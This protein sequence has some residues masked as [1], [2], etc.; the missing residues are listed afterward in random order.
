MG[1]RAWRGGRDWAKERWKRR[2][3]IAKIRIN[4]R[5]KVPFWRKGAVSPRF[6]IDW[7]TGVLITPLP[8]FLLVILDYL[9][10]NR[11]GDAGSGDLGAVGARKWVDG[12]GLDHRVRDLGGVIL[13]CTRGPPLLQRFDSDESSR[14]PLDIA[15]SS[16]MIATLIFLSN[17][18]FDDF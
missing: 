5:P 7:T 14:R 8:E 17:S 16:A 4:E 2:V 18:R 6:T 15:P 11:L 9:P 1:R 10:T 13:Q 12:I 3:N